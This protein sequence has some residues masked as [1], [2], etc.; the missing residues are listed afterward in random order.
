MTRIVSVSADGPDAARTALETCVVEGGVTVFPA[1]GLYG[2]ACDPLDPDAIGRIHEL[3]GRP[4]GKPSAVMYFSPLAL[5]ELIGYLAPRAREIASRLLPGPVTLVISNPDHRYPLACGDDPGRLGIRLIEG[6]LAGAMT[7]VFQTS[8]N[9]SG[10]PAPADFAAIAQA[11]RD[12]A[13]LAIDG[14]RLGGEPSTV[15]DLSELDDG[16]DWAV[17]REGALSAAELE[18]M[19]A[20]I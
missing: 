18:R 1:D 20:G 2:L 17:L 9:P 6:P 16:G 19:L 11:I 5:R 10:A 14:G 3:K 7:P 15:I 12:G 4:E 13:D 8:A